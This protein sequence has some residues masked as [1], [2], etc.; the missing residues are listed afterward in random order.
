[1]TYHNF[2]EWDGK[3]AC[4]SRFYKHETTFK[5]LLALWGE[6]KVKD[7][8][9]VLPAEEIYVACLSLQSVSLGLIG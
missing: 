1:M 9:I 8:G 3:Y 6:L 7:E 5:L 2:L 4:V